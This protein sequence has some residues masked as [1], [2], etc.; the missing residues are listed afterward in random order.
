MTQTNDRLAARNAVILAGAQGLGGANATII[1]TTGG[2]IGINL[3]PDPAWATV[4]VTMF[5]LGQAVATL[6]AGLAMRRIGRRAGFIIGAGFG[7]LGMLL[8]AYA[9]ASASFQMFLAATFLAGIYQAH[10]QFY[11]FAAADTA[12]PAFRP[13]AISWVLVGGIA[14]ALFGAQLVIWTRDVFAPYTFVG[15]FAAALLVTGVAILLLCL[16]NIPRAK[17]S[18]EG[19][20]RPLL[21]IVRQPRFVV[22]VICAVT[23]Y[24]L[25]SFVMTAAPLAMLACNYGVTDAALAIQWHAV[26]MFAPSFFTGHLIARYGEPR[27]IMTGMAL[28]AGCGAVAL[29]GIEIAHFWIA[30]ILLGVG[31]NFGFVGA[32]SLLTQCYRPSEKNKAQAVND[33]IVFG[34]VAIASA[35]SGKVLNLYGWEMVNIAMFPAIA[36]AV[37]VIVWFGVTG[38][39]ARPVEA[40]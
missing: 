15:T 28:L 7:A 10:I 19:P 12:S 8:A 25:M 38:R 36:L 17:Q 3:A 26:A 2:I 9:V 32:T 30:L 40:P 16:L 18:E 39:A 6:P 34:S 13:K 23:S 5:V 21:D 20:Q 37:A 1:I 4:P 22:A 24:A 11:R 27:I 33:F 35:L 29:M 14:A 31:W